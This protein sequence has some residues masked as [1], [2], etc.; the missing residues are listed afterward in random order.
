LHSRPSTLLRGSSSQSDFEDWEVWTLSS[1]GELH[2]TR[3]LPGDEEDLFVASP[4]P[5]ARLGKRSVA[6]AFGNV[7]KVVAVDV[8]RF[9]EDIDEWRG[10]AVVSGGR[11][12]RG[13]PRKDI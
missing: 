1:N 9:E 4:G 7:I 2:A 5:I 12:R 10:L 3:L 13:V 11:R 8:D 6:I